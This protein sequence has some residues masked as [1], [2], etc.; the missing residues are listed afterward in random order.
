MEVADMFPTDEAAAKWFEKWTWPN[1]EINCLYK[2]GNH[3]TPGHTDPEPVVCT[4]RVTAHRGRKNHEVV[5]HS[6]GEDVRYLAGTKVHTNG[7]ESF[8]SMLKRGYLGAYH[9]MS[10][11]HLQWYVNEFAGWHYIRDMD[12][13]DQ[14]GP[15]VTG[16][17]DQRLLCG[18]RTGDQKLP[19]HS[20]EHTWDPLT[21][22][23]NAE[24]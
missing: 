8:R 1:G 19:K 10:P 14:M 5:H 16:M 11:K 9:R 18:D 12:T 21:R 7:V 2:D 24:K 4:D 3:L 13:I 6:V 15:V 22:R 23:D 17:I 20:R